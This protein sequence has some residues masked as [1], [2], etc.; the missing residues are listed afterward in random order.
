M[1][2]PGQVCH[3]FAVDYTHTSQVTTREHIVPI[4]S[5]SYLHISVTKYYSEDMVPYIIFARLFNLDLPMMEI[6]I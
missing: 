2:A 1:T 5:S 4:P 6:F 3:K